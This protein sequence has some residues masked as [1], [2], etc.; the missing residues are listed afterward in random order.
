MNDSI[1]SVDRVTHLKIVVIAL[2]AAIAMVSIVTSD[3]IRSNIGT[4][5]VVKAG[6]LGAITSL[7]LPVTR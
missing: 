2:A 5:A 1:Y 4:V 6:K 7:N 3:H